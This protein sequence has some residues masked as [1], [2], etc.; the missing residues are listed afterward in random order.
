LVTKITIP[1]S[2]TSISSCSF[3]NCSSLAGI[4]IP[5]SVTSI[6]DRAFY[7]CSSLTSITIPNSVT[8][9]DDYTFAYCDK[10]A[11]ITIPNSVTSVGNDA[12]YYC[13]SLTDVYYTGT[14]SEWNGISIE[15]NNSCL[16]NATIHFNHSKQDE[17]RINEITLTDILGSNLPTI[18]K[19]NF[20]ATV[21]LTNVSSNTDAVI[22]LAQYTSADIL[23][24]LM[25]I[26]IEDIPTGS[27]ETPS[28]LVDNSQGDIATL[29]AFCWESL[30]SLIPVSNTASFPA[31]QK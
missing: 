26:P 12:F 21:S 18:P 17:Y 4:T 22:I 8:S 19:G 2:V 10:L 1:N 15:A 14:E 24:G 11:G 27:T 23:K 29:K 6:G 3:Y 31:Q 30:N 5:N 25:Y 7:N 16:T 28:V 9:I 20:L 13:D